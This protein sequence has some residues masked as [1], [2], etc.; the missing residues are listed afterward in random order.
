[1]L[2]EFLSIAGQGLSVEDVTSRQ[3]FKRPAKVEE[4]AAMILF[5]LS[6]ESAFI[7]GENHPVS[8]GWDL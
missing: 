7:T 1:M 8:G 6:D 4:V 3:L 2:S 5:L